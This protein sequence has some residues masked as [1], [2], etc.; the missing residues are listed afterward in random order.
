V[1]PPA[2]TN[3]AKLHLVKQTVGNNIGLRGC[4][5]LIGVEAIGKEYSGY[6]LAEAREIINTRLADQTDGHE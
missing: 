2:K 4:R 3:Y 6:I 5:W 1:P